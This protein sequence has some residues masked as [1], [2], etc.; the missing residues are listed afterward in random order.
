MRSWPW[1]VL[2]ALAAGCWN[3]R[4]PARAPAVSIA[5]LER[6]PEPWPS[7]AR[8]R[9]VAR[10]PDRCATVISHMF[11]LWMPD[12]TLIAGFSAAMFDELRAAGV[13]SCHATGWS[14]EIL[15]CFEDTTSMDETTGCTRSMTEE[16]LEDLKRRVM[17]IML[18]QQGAT[19]PTPPPP[20]SPPS[21]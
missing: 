6:E 19:T 14:D 8:A 15:S 7:R 17:D 16:Q 11:D 20:A 10:P 21:P 5:Q 3:E 18:R 4:A 12:V 13:E 9:S 2:V 1:L